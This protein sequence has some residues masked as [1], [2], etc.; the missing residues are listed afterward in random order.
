MIEA[1]F[2]SLSPVDAERL[3]SYTEIPED[4]YVDLLRFPSAEALQELA[5][6]LSCDPAE[7][8]RLIRIVPAA[9]A[10]ILR[11]GTQ[12][13]RALLESTTDELSRAATQWAGEPSWKELDVNPMDLTGDTMMLAAQWT[14]ASERGQPLYV[15]INSAV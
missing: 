1:A 3:V 5:A 12:F 4:A 15:W 11:A 7:S 6:L 10:S 2:F 13:E 9:N 14:L 8:F